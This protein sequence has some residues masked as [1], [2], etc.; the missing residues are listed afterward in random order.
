MDDFTQHKA[1]LIMALRG[2]GILSAPVLSAL[3]SIPREIFVPESLRQHA[4]ENASLPI[5]LDQTISQPYV[6]ARMTEAL[7]LTGRE[8]VL[9][10]GTGSGYQAAILTL[11]CRRVYTLE[12]L[13]PLLVAAENK[14]RA[15]RIS[16]ISFRLGDGSAGWPEAAP[17]DRIILTCGCDK[18]PDK[19]LNQIKIGG[20]MVAPEGD[21]KVQQ[22]VV[23]KRHETG[24]DRKNL[25][26]VTFVPLIEDK[27][28]E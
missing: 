6:V 20:I 13:K 2:Q 24:F 11:L 14:L 7:E 28:D 18:I 26:S 25:M 27:Q 12:R 23:V 1:Q 15:L 17:F 4:Y 8:R 10:I 22:L 5:A 3:E 9:E 19:L 21:G 16:N